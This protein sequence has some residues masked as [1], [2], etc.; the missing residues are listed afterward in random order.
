MT[1]RAL[2]PV[3]A[4]L[5]ALSWV[6]TSAQGTSVS[7]EAADVS[8]G[9]AAVAADDLPRASALATSAVAKY[10][11]SLAVGVL[12]IHTRLLTGGSAAALAQYEQWLGTAAADEPYLV[13][14]V[15]L[16]L[17]RETVRS[18]RAS[19][20]QRRALEALRGEGDDTTLA[21]LAP[22]AD[23]GNLIAM[24]GLGAL[25]DEAAVRKLI[26]ALQTGAG[27]RRRAIEALA[28]TGSRLAV[29]PLI[30]VLSDPLPNNQM[31]AAK[32]LGRLRA[33]EAVGPL[34]ALLEAPVFAVR[35]AAAGALFQLRDNA[36][37]TFL[38]GL[39]E[40]PAPM[41]RAQAL[42]AM[43]SDPDMTWQGDVR[44]LLN[45]PDP[46][47][48]LLAARLIG[49]HDP[50]AAASVVQGMFADPN[51]SIA[52]D[53]TTIYAERIASDV[54]GLRQ[55][56][57]NGDALVRVNAAARILELTR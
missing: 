36:G 40:S 31:E 43:A 4:L 46:Q 14:L 41:L 38:R 22:A 16:G 10:P 25:G 15:A 8:A 33:P 1:R 45:D 9:W 23:A 55:L 18:A 56:L 32:A 5:A 49:P 44:G 57:K 35:F 34:R 39:L 27:D 53:A 24:E 54:A 28:A 48:R 11:H 42:E 51:V 3:A 47:V 26:A 37:I 6:S 30:A 29:P 20:E 50:A 52:Q 12:A 21:A 19:T 7:S 2:V 13:R 17:L